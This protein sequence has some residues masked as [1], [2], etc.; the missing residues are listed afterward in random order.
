MFWELNDNF[1]KYFLGFPNS[2]TYEKLKKILG[3]VENQFPVFEKNWVNC[4]IRQQKTEGETVTK[5]R[6]WISFELNTGIHN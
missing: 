4:T 5:Q 2:L 1:L 3:T 6:T